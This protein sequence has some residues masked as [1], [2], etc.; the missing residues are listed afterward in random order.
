MKVV[1]LTANA[2][3]APHRGDALI[4]FNQIPGLVE[5]AE[6]HLISFVTSDEEDRQ[7]RAALGGYCAS[8][9][10]VQDSAWRRYLRPLRTLWNGLPLQVNLHSAGRMRRVLRQVIRDHDIDLVHIQTMRMAGLCDDLALPCVVDLIDALSL[11]M[12]RRAEKEH[13]QWL[14]PLLRLEQTLAHRYEMRLLKKFQGFTVAAEQDRKWLDSDVI[15]V[16][17]G[18]TATPNP[19]LAAYRHITRQKRMIFQGNMYYFPNVEAVLDIAKTIW[20]ALHARFPDYEFY[21]V[22]HRPAPEITRL[23]NQDNIV[24]TG[25]VDDMVAELCAAEIGIYWLST[26]TGLQTKVIDALSCG[27]PSVVNPR[28]IQ[29]FPGLTEE[30]VVLA[31]T[32]EDFIE[33]VA[34]LLADPERQAALSVA[35]REYVRQHHSWESNIATLLEV[36]E[37]A[38]SSRSAAPK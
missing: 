6:I 10:T 8:I 11:N 19:D 34:A 28:A 18:G 15:R 12:Q 17:P 29:G 25:G 24:V 3:F 23:H 20:P 36:W 4:A 32:R 27:L 16:N 35:G 33:A 9:H 37:N 5:K 13:R 22:G 14:K 7:L 1:Y 38:V 2:P 21:V 31:E 30:H 26:G